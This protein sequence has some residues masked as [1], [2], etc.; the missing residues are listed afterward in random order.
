VVRDLFHKKVL[1][2]VLARRQGTG[3]FGAA[4]T[5]PPSVEDTYLAL[6][7]LQCLAPRAGDEVSAVIHDPSLA[8]FLRNP[9]DR[10]EWHPKTGF[11]YAYCCRLTGIVP[12]GKW[13]TQFI[14]DR[15]TNFSG[16]ADHFFCLRMMKEI[17]GP[18]F[19]NPLTFFKD[20]F[21]IRWRSA[22]EL[23]MALVIAGG[24][25]EKFDTNRDN[26]LSWLRSC[27]NPDGGF[28]F[29]PGTTSYME[30]VHACLRSLTLLQAAP[31]N[32]A[33]ADRFI[34]NAWTKGGGF[35]RKN[36]GA[37]FLDATW[38]AVAALSILGDRC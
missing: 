9:E 5:L 4:P 20:F 23:W 30:N 3:A 17:P 28:G 7:T 26:L 6:R 29:L 36:G 22:R 24:Q 18:P 15:L 27:Q 21:P 1:E 16:L 32:P 14:S 25:P 31:L 19:E 13:V 2:F 38:H 37:P 33:G 12:D 8:Q 35:A 11:H 10:E 34:M